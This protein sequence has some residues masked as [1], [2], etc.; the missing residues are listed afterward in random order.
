VSLDNSLYKPLPTRRA[1]QEIVDQI[2]GLIYAKKL[3][4]GDKLPPERELASHFGAGRMAVREAFRVLEQAGLIYIKQGVDGG[5]FV[6]EVDLSVVTDSLSNLIRR[7][8]ISLNDFITVR[9]GV[10]RLIIEAIH[11]Y[12]NETLL[13]NLKKTIEDTASL[14][15]II[16]SGKETYDASALVQIGADFH[17]ELARATKNP[18]FEI[19]QESIVK[20]MSIFMGQ[21]PYDPEFH[22]DHLTFH[23]EIYEALRIKNISLASDELT[24]HSQ[25]ML[26]HFANYLPLKSS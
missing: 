21:G 1:Y 5:A 11:E 16:E 13:E 17:L 24:K 7:S 6:K 22:K 10:E 8:S 26:D 25:F 20:A 9:M 12:I 18:L 19:L 2:S 23:I 4:P 3:N 14:L 15:Q